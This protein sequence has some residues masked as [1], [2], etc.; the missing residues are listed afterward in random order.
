VLVRCAADVAEELGVALRSPSQAVADGLLGALTRD[1]PRGVEEILSRTGQ[2]VQ[3]VLAE[4]MT[5][6]MEDKVRRLPGALYVR[7]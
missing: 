6:E 3:Q 1:C 2:S 4:L 7:N 5:L